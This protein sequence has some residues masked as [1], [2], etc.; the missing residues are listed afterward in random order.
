MIWFLNLIT[1]SIVNISLSVG[2]LLW[3]F[4]FLLNFLPLIQYRVPTQI[5]SI[6]ILVPS[7]WFYSFFHYQEEQKRELLILQERINVAENKSNDLNNQL[8]SKIKELDGLRNKKNE[9]ITKVITKVVKEY[10][11]KCELSNAFIRVHDSSSQDEVP[12]SSEP[13][14]GGTSDVKASE[15]L[16]TV[17]I[18]YSTY[19]QMRNRLIQWQQWYIKQKEI[20]EDIQK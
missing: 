4:G 19:Y 20:F 9:V 17:T 18:N 11:N 3:I 14:D 5:L 6:V 12:T 2:L 16:Q 1:E 13:T 7:I 10:D 15:L 8:Q